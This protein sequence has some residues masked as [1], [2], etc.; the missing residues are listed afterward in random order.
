M[1]DVPEKDGELARK[2]LAH[3]D[4]MTWDRYAQIA[5]DNARSN[6]DFLKHGQSLAA[7]RG[8]EVGEGDT[9]FNEPAWPAAAE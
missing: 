8:Q 9:A 1:I 5:Y 3:M 2:L 6:F 7:L 4:Q